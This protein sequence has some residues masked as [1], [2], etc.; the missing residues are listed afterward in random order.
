MKKVEKYIAEDGTVFDDESDCIDY[1]T[2][3]MMKGNV[4]LFDADGGE[5]PAER[6]EE[7]FYIWCGD[8]ENAQSVIENLH[9]VYGGGDLPWVS[10][11]YPEAGLIYYY[12]ESLEIWSTIDEEI[13]R[14]K[15]RLSELEVMK[16][17]IMGGK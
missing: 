12:D 8:S 13:Y 6:F 11:P 7:C 5:I 14:A 9:Y 3:L 2:A 16:K 1:E 10:A 15:D 17:K 4:K